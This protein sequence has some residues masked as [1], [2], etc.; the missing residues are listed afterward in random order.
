M[1][2]LLDVRGDKVGDYRYKRS[3]NGDLHFLLSVIYRD[4]SNSPYY[5]SLFSIEGV[6]NPYLLN[7]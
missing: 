6:L 5:I 2:E 4:D 7:I 3:A 1:G